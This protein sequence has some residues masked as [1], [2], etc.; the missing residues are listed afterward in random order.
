[1]ACV[2]LP[3]GAVTYS[4]TITTADASTA[5]QIVPASGSKSFT[6][7]DIVIS[8]DTELT[9]SLQDDSGSPVVIMNGMYFP[10]TSIWSKTWAAGLPV[11]AGQ[12]LDV[13]ASGAGNVSVTVTGYYK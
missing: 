8:T 12:D 1:M 6:L 5:T 10:A 7:I 4:N 9:I 13:L 3:I 11:T 2:S